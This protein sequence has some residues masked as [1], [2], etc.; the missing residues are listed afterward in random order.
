MF[1]YVPRIAVLLAEWV[2]PARSDQKTPVVAC[3]LHHRRWLE[4]LLLVNP[5]GSNWHVEQTLQMWLFSLISPYSSNPG[6]R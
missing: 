2:L 3:D 5:E 6:V 1:C 4:G